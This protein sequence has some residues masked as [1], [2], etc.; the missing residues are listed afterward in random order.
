MSNVD[1][2]FANPAIKDYFEG[3]TQHP[4]ISEF[5]HGHNHP[6]MYTFLNQLEAA[7]AEMAARINSFD[8]EQISRLPSTFASN[9][10]SI[11]VAISQ[12]VQDVSYKNAAEILSLLRG[13]YK[14]CKEVLASDF[15]AT[16][17]KKGT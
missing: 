4:P 10:E 7:V 1:L 8:E 3:R 14:M 17:L 13:L 6:A 5:L 12:Q 16:L 11:F 9:L 15:E 2:T